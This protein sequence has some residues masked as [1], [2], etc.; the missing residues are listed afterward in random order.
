MQRKLDAD[1]RKRTQDEGLHR[2]AAEPRYEFASQSKTLKATV[3]RATF[4]PA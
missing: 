1:H 2:R 4:F 3:S